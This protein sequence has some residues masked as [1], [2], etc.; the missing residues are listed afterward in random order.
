MSDA[1][2]GVVGALG[3]VAITGV[4][5]LVTAYLN[6]R[7]SGEQFDLDL[8]LKRSE[9]RRSAYG[10]YLVAAQL[11]FDELDM[12]TPK[13]MSVDNMQRVY[14]DEL[15]ESTR[16]FQSASELALL[17]AGD[18]VIPHIEA[19]EEWLGEYVTRSIVD[20]LTEGKHAEVAKDENEN[21]GA[22]SAQ[23][24]R[25]TASEIWNDQRVERVS[26]MRTAM[27]REQTK[28]LSR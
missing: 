20:A 16:A 25:R 24:D 11:F 10:A 19:F 12:W 4:I 17:L 18:E 15:G 6:H 21:E 14:K 27:R 8:R 1:W 13:H 28:D 26:A 3:G 23:E 5:A 7:W 9:L 22:R 2:I